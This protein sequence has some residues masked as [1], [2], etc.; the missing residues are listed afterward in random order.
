MNKLS[1]F[2][3]S[4]FVVVFLQGCISS[5]EKQSGDG[6]KG[7]AYYTVSRNNFYGFDLLERPANIP[8]NAKAQIDAN[9]GGKKYIFADSG[10]VFSV[11]TAY[12]NDGKLTRLTLGK[13]HA[14]ASEADKFWRLILDKAKETYPREIVVNSGI[15]AYIRFANSREDWNQQYREFKNTRSMEAFNVGYHKHLSTIAFDQFAGKDGKIFTTIDYITSAYQA[16]RG[17][18]TDSLKRKLDSI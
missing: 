18:K 1:L 8:A 2:F 16:K 6:S 13:S 15:G 3:L 12:E 14:S 10:N 11:I 17:T 4:F 5:P 9:T 7:F